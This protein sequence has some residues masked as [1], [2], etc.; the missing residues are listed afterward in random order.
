MP[1]STGDEGF[2]EQ[3]KAVEREMRERREQEEGDLVDR[4][5]EEQQRER[6]TVEDE[7]DD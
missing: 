1:G 6:E 7:H 2:R 5:G 3:R 4:V